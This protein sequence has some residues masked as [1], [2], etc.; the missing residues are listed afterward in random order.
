MNR[1]LI[2]SKPTRRQSVLARRPDRRL[3]ALGLTTETTNLSST[4]LILKV[5]KT[6]KAKKNPQARLSHLKIKKKKGKR[7]TRLLPPHSQSR[8][9]WRLRLIRILQ[10][11]VSLSSRW[12]KKVAPTI[13]SLLR[14][15]QS[16]RNHRRRHS[17][18]TLAVRSLIQSLLRMLWTVSRTGRKVS[19]RFKFRR[20]IV[21]TKITKMP[22]YKVKVWVRTS[23]WV[24]KKL[25][26]IRCTTS[27][28]TTRTTA[29][30]SK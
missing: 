30:R 22:W 12:K 20:P 27:L 4:L 3:R 24:T 17:P 16:L 21:V 9:R 23:T 2:I 18:N 10:A 28:G 5:V 7:A 11:W 13:L 19:R 1:I 29:Q 14:R 6:N 15:H 8:W 26:S 25:T